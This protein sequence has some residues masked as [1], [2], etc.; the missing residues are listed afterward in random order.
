MIKKILIVIT[1]SSV[2]FAKSY[3]VNNTIKSFTLTDQFDKVHQVDER[4]QTIIVSFE[5]GTG[6]DINSFLSTKSP[7]FLEKHNTVFIANISGMPSFVTTMFALP[8]M[9]KYEHSILLIY[10][11]EDTRFLQEEEKS[12]VYKLKN[13]IVQRIYYIT[14]KDLET[15]F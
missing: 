3:D 8:K 5:K 15:E 2:L 14:Q 6:A 4:I 12:T 9:R 11:E 10:D 1:L 13:G 7:D